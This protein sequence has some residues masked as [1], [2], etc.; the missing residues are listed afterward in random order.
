MPT[1]LLIEAGQADLLLISWLGI[2]FLN[3][4]DGTLDFFEPT[5]HLR[6]D[7]AV[8]FYKVIGQLLVVLFR[9][10]SISLL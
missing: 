10:S 1:G 7:R 4:H 3:R 8:R 6:Q 9:H 5:E 2:D